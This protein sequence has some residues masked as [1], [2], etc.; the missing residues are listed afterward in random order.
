VAE[1]ASNAAKA[2]KDRDDRIARKL[3]LRK[4]YGEVRHLSMRLQRQGSLD[5]TNEEI[6]GAVQGFNQLKAIDP[7]ALSGRWGIHFVPR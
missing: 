5:Q 1:T 7:V 4:D 3:P 2:A 6:Q